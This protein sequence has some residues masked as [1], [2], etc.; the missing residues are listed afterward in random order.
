[1]TIATA[2]VA[3]QVTISYALPTPSVATSA[4]PGSAAVGA[5]LADE[6][7]V[8]GGANP[9]GTVTFELF[10]NDSCSGTALLTD[11]ENLSGAA[12]SSTAYTTT[13]AGTFYWEAT[14][15]G[16]A[17]NNAA[18]TPCSAE[19][20]V[21]SVPSPPSAGT[22]IPPPVAPTGV[23]AT[24]GNATVT[25]GAFAL[26]WHRQRPTGMIYVEVQLPGPGTV[27]LL[28]THSDPATTASAAQ[29]QITA[30]PERFAYGR[31]SDITIT[32]AGRVQV[33]LRP[34]AAGER[35]LRRHATYG[36]A[37]HVRVWIIYTPTGGATRL[38]RRT[39]R[40]LAA[41]R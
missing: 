38:L 37:L 24:G 17:N 39:V 25:Q 16:D 41:H 13:V 19:P 12:A 21:V 36:M 18:S 11:T 4:Q 26:L 28:G 31:R 7:S 32:K 23:T 30:G 2:S 34:N 3:P 15:N 1:V 14:Y 8:T 35:L 9:T 10:S 22:P 27:S 6:A 29:A 5:M 33:A 40:V 20:V